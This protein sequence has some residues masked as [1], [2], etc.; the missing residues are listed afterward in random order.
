MLLSGGKR[1]AWVLNRNAM[2]FEVA[3]GGRRQ[4]NCIDLMQRPATPGMR[5]AVLPKENTVE[6]DEQGRLIH[7]CPSGTGLRRR[8][9]PSTKPD[10]FRPRR[11]V[12]LFTSV[13]SLRVG[14][15]CSIS[16]HDVLPRMASAILGSAFDAFSLL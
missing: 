16:V 1:V 11:N 4:I 6:G 14:V 2:T 9:T 5:V 8:F 12:L 13:R 15:F 3:V 10:I 7:Y